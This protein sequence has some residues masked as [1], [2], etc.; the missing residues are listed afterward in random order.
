[1]INKSD[2][3]FGNDMVTIKS[4][5]SRAVITVCNTEC[6]EG[7]KYFVKMIRPNDVHESM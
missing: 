7:C 1:M 3:A 2:C 6:K 4:R 5:V